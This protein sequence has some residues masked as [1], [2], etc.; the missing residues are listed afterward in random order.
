VPQGGG[1]TRSPGFADGIRVLA[2]SGEGTL[3][4]RD[5]PQRRPHVG[6]VCAVDST[7]HPGEGKTGDVDLV[8]GTKIVMTVVM[9]RADVRPAPDDPAT[10]GDEHV[11]LL[12]APG[13]DPQPVSLRGIRDD[14]VVSGRDFLA[15]VADID[16]LDTDGGAGSLVVVRAAG[17]GVPAQRLVLAGVPAAIFQ[18][19]VAINALGEATPDA[20]MGRGLAATLGLASTEQTPAVSEVPGC[21]PMPGH[22]HRSVAGSRD[23]AT[24]DGVPRLAGNQVIVDLE[25]HDGPEYS[26]IRT[27]KF[28]VQSEIGRLRRVLIHRPGHEIDRM[29]PVMMEHL[30]FDDILDGELARREHDAFR[31][32]LKSAAVEVLDPA[33]L[34]VECLADEA[35][36]DRLLGRLESENG[37]P[38]GVLATLAE[39]PPAALAT[40]L[41]AGILDP[42]PRQSSDGSSFYHL[43]PVP[44]YFFQR[45]PQVVMGDRVLISSMT[46]TA[47]GRE[48][49][50]ARTIFESHP[51]LSG[52]SD[53]FQLDEGIDEPLR[54]PHVEGGDLLVPSAEVI[55]MGVSERTDRWGVE[56][57]ARYLRTHKTSFKYL[58]VVEI[59]RRRSYMHLDTVFT[60]IDRGQALAYMP[61]I[62]AGGSEVGHV[63]LIEL[64]A[65]KLAYT[66]CDDLPRTLAE[67]GL[68][69]ELIP[70]GGRES[71]I[72][73][74]RE[75]WT[76]GA[77]A[78]AIAPGVIVLYQRNR[79][80]IEELARRGFRVVRE[81]EVLA[82]DA[83]V[84]GHGPTVISLRGREL[85]R[86][87]GGPRCMTMPLFRDHL[88]G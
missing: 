44:N 24:V 73:Q 64:E 79:S 78:V 72:G 31:Q 75:Q 28:Q 15:G 42:D 13:H 71:L 34:L 39:M 66:V 41:L 52:W 19:D 37:A 8:P 1:R 30:L 11:D 62:E 53:L 27:V 58:I 55:L 20:V 60:F 17:R 70:C 21:R 38:Q 25:A 18:S 76:D 22:G 67:V 23:P 2:Q 54:S 16:G 63:G 32:I 61:A 77:N 45:D 3:T 47:R 85:S 40:A 69:I 5:R 65:P 36:R 68:P 46:K 4:S 9:A 12:L 48:P 35:V 87:R 83:E 88:D 10:Q 59:P 82:G 49:L 86:A 50:L 51:A 43:A 26:K 84:L 56:A 74:Q 80:T 14:P 33:D 7:Q 57:L 81:E 29:A 6:N